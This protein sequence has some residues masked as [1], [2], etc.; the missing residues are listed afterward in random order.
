MII[1]CSQNF[2][3]IRSYRQVD[4]VSYSKFSEAL[5]LMFVLG[6]R[7][8]CVAKIRLT[9]RT[10]FCWLPRQNNALTLAVPSELF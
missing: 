3:K 10:P 5:L 2:K 7:D 4:I 6:L 8:W 1:D 9:L